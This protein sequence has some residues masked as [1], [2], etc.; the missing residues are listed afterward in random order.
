MYLLLPVRPD[1]AAVAQ[2]AQ[3]LV[4]DVLSGLQKEAGKVLIVTA[5]GTIV[6]WLDRLPVQRRTVVLGALA[7]VASMLGGLLNDG[8]AV[9]RVGGVAVISAVVLLA[10]MLG[11]HLRTRPPP[12]VPDEPRPPAW[13]VGLAWAALP[14]SAVALGVPVWLIIGSASQRRRDAARREEETRREL[15]ATRRELS[16]LQRELQR[17]LEVLRGP[18]LASG[19]SDEP[20]VEGPGLHRQAGAGSKDPPPEAAPPPAPRE[21]R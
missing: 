3:K 6:P 10:V 11:E 5:F 8:G 13:R 19:S 14:T 2:G 20:S 7:L 21:H 9:S 12:P 18:P 17:A 4:L 1:G 16:A 15:T